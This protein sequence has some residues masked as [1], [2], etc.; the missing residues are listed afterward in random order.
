[1]KKWYV[2]FPFIIF[3]VLTYIAT[4]KFLFTGGDILYG[5]FFGSKDYIFFFKQFLNAWAEYTGLGNSNIGLSTSYG[6]NPLFFVVPPGYQ[7]P[8]LSIL[9]IMQFIFGP[10]ASRMYIIVSIV[11]PFIGMYFLAKYWFKDLN[12]NNVILNLAGLTSSV[13]YGASGQ[14]VSRVSAGHLK[15]SWGH[16]LFPLLL[17]ASFQGF[18]EKNGKKRFFYILTSGLLIATLVWSMPQ[19]LSLYVILLFFYFL[20]FMFPN[21]EKITK[22]ITFTGIA[23]MIGAILSIHIWLPGIIYP[24]KLS[25]IETPYYSTSYV[26]IT[27]KG[28]K[29]EEILANSSGSEKAFIGEKQYETLV[30]NKLKLPIFASF[31]LLFAFF[32]LRNLKRKS[33]FLFFTAASGLI[34]AWGINYPFE[35][36]YLF[37]FS[38]V[39]LFKPFRDVGKFSILYVL[40]LSLLIPYILFF[41]QRFLGKI[42]VV[43]AAIL[44]SL[45]ILYV[46]PSFRSGNFGDIIVPFDLPKKYEKLNQYLS[47]DPGDFRVAVYPN[48]KYMGHYDWFPKTLLPSSYFNIFHVLFP[49]PK[50]LAISNRTMTDWTSRYL[51]Y[52]ELNLD[53][54][55]AAERLGEERVK[56]I[57]V[58]HSL[59]DHEKITEHLNK[60][61][62]VKKIKSIEG[63]TMFEIMEYNTQ[64]IKQKEAVY[65][66]GDVS[67]VKY[68]S[69]K[70][71][72]INLLTEPLEILDKNYS[73]Y[74]L[75]YNSSLN[76]VFFTGLDKFKIS[77]FP[78]VRFPKDN[79][80]DFYFP[81]EYLRSLTQ[82]GIAFY[83]PEIIRTEGLHN[84]IQKQFTFKPGKYKMLLSTASTLGQTN[85]L[86]IKVGDDT[87]VKKNFR[88][89]SEG[90]EWID[91]GEIAINTPNVN[92]SIEDLEP[93][94]L[95]VDYFLLIPVKEYKKLRDEFYSKINSKKIIQ[96]DKPISEELTK[97]NR[98]NLQVLSQSY[99]PYWDICNSDAI[100]VNFY[101]TGSSCRT[102][103]T[104][105]SKFKPSLLYTISVFLSFSFYLLS[106][107]M[108]LRLKTQ[109]K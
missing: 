95:Y 103:S 94:S 74:V 98:K 23:V 109:K 77:F 17:L 105:V 88:K 2:F 65:Y 72:L 51:D 42:G 86:R 66:F 31:G 34:F 90:M 106:L 80:K 52:L 27:S 1:M 12:R 35:K 60:N 45:F 16:G 78:E 100:R 71:A 13:I 102:D 69:G 39:F 47:A 11:L 48:D 76:D 29:F 56:L 33:L 22:M 15:Y 36:T 50:N 93:G 92:I 49:L 21:V 38:K 107:F 81:A 84:T 58:D 19:L 85:S 26:N 43:V 97:E 46:N 44:L 40:G 59:P 14:M 99:S 9:A 8:F 5:E 4:R 64:P 68:L 104:R 18:E 70:L 101:G 87:M 61:P 24:E 67:G 73:D 57:I 75:L 6:L 96:V 63:F 79:A 53:Q 7:L 82:M 37:L 89:K 62:K 10:F 25:Y 28:V 55:W 91:F 20:L 30:Q 54:P 32:I 41:I 3:L 108:L 83:N